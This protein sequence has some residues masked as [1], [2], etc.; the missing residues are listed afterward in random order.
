MK[1]ILSKG[2]VIVSLVSVLAILATSLVSVFTGTAL[3]ALADDADTGA[4]STTVT[5]PLSGSYDAD[6]VEVTTPGI[7][8]K[9]VDF[10]KKTKTDIF[11]GFDVNFCVDPNTEGNG[12][13][14]DPYIIKTANQFAAVVTCNL[15]DTNGNWLDTDGL[16]F[17]IADDIYGFNLNNTGS[18]VDFSK[19]TL[20]AADVEAELKD[21]GVPDELKWQNSSSKPF[22][23]R[24]DGNGACV[25]GLKGNAT[26]SAIFPIIGGNI[27]VK[28]LTVKNCYFIGSNVSAFFG[29]NQNPGKTSTYNT[30]HYLYSCQAYGNVVI[31][32]YTADEAIQKAGILIGQSMWPT[33]SNLIVNDC[34]V[35]DNIAKH[36]ENGNGKYNITYGLVGNLHRGGS[37]TINNSIVMGTASHPMYW[38]SN[39]Q[40][41]STYNNLYTDMMGVDAWENVDTAKNGTQYTYTYTYVLSGTSLTN[42]FNRVTQEGV[43][44][45]SSGNGLDH[46]LSSSIIHKTT[47]ADV[48]GST[49]SLEGIDAERW[50][51]NENGYP[52][53]K[54]YYVREYSA[55]TN[56]SGETA[57]QYGEGDGISGSPYTIAT[58]EEL[59]LMLMNPVAGAYYKLVAD[60]EINDTTAA[61]WTATAKK[62][63]TS[64]DVPAFEA[65]FDG[66]GYT[67][68][69]IYYDG[70]Q[71][72]EYAGLIPVVGNTAEIR[73]VKIA[74]SYIKANKGYAGALAGA[75]A[76]KCG[77]AVKFDAC[78]IE[79]TVKFEGTAAFG[80]MIGKIGYSMLHINDCISMT[81]GIF[82]T[83]TGEAKLKRCVSVGANVA[84]GNFDAKDVKAE[85]VYTDVE[86]NVEGVTVV[87]SEAMVGEAAA[88]SMPGLNFPTSWATT[89]GYPAPTGVA[90]SAEG[91]VGEPWSGAI[92]TSYALVYENPNNPGEAWQGDGTEQYPYVIETAEQLAYFVWK[93]EQGTKDKIIHI[94][95]A[96]DIYLSDVNSKLWADKIGGTNWFNQRTTKTYNNIKGIEF[97]GDGYVIHGLF[98]DN[99]LSKG[100]Y[101]RA[102]LFPMLGAYSTVK[103]VGISNAYLVGRTNDATY[104]DC[105]AAY[106]GCLED[107]DKFMGFNSNDAEANVAKMQDPDLGWE[108]MAVKFQNCFVDHRSYISAYCTGAFVAEPYS[109]PILENCIFTGTIQGH[110]DPYY[111]GIFTGCDSTY[112]SQLRYCVSFPAGSVSKLI[113]GSGGANWRNSVAS[114]V[115]IATGVYYFGT[116]Q[117]YGGAFTKLSNPN[118]RIGEEAVDAMPLLDWEN[119]WRVVDG[120]TPILTIFD[121]HRSNG[122]VE[123]TA[124]KRV[125]VDA[126]YFSLVDYTPPTTKLTFS[127][128]DPA[129]DKQMEANGTNILELPM[130][131]SEGFELPVISRQG[132]DFLGWF[133]WEDPAIP[134]DYG[135][136]PPRDLTLY[137]GWE[138]KG[139]V[140]TF[141]EYPDTIWDIDSDYWQLNKPGAKGG[142]KNKYVRNG[143]KSMHLLGATSGSVDCLLNYEQMLEP[144]KAY[145]ISFWVNTDKEDNDP[146]LLSLVHNSKPDYLNSSI[147]VENMAVATNLKVGEWVQYSYS[148]TAK[149]KWV[150][151]RTTGAA[152]LWFDDVMMAELDGELSGSNFVGITRNGA[153]FGTVSTVNGFAVSNGNAVS[154]TVIISTIIACAIVAVIS[155]KNLVEIVED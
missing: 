152:S 3:V 140:Q 73:N 4:D 141:D 115:T 123:D 131:S 116:S 22:K 150:S 1:R 11:T 32:T 62:W 87:P 77:K 46:A 60:I 20:T 146:V 79:D 83:V 93:G 145:T 94:K 154:L 103:N 30:K 71:A 90:A 75:V 114:Q 59:A 100:E 10:S 92:A 76:D 57:V 42:K 44:D 21:A 8:Y 45:V 135:Y 88:T 118:Q 127:S 72:G 126:E 124:N 89:T 119:T 125:Q 15:K 80:G 29:V 120:G 34:L 6:Y 108:E 69:G 129:I 105:I 112:G 33:E 53:P 13:A 50:T 70:T 74:D 117:S 64:N 25:Y 17:K 63:F 97:D 65:S 130:Y 78:V 98:I 136:Q 66:N 18:S 106:V 91:V 153:A 16:Y 28:N 109:S 54:V 39:A 107:F 68:S 110:D 132:Y 95:L 23:G 96:A 58:A 113:G 48:K 138:Q 155:R 27:T 7:E 14:G 101:I 67:V 143:S 144:G 128:G 43:S 2:K 38:G 147:G 151:L 41:Q 37:L 52:R 5:Y 134:Y 85:N 111:T 137:A 122:E 36:S 121:K 86:T 133:V 99:T 26:Y 104:R 82:N 148:F 149:T 142:Y 31:C 47:A 24:F 19:D 81:N 139:V 102:G 40:L 55:G 61:D 84:S 12:T 9:E 56:W 51:Y 35:Y 49:K